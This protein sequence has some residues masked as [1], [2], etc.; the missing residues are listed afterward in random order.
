MRIQS[1]TVPTVALLLAAF[2]RPSDELHF[3]PAEKTVVVKSFEQTTTFKSDSF[4]MKIGDNEI[5]SEQLGNIKFSVEENVKLGV[6]DEYMKVSGGRPTKLK[7]TY[8]TIE[9]KATQTM[10]QGDEDGDKGEEK[11]KKTDLAGKTVIFTWDEK[12]EECAARRSRRRPRL[13]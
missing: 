11:E 8:D 6:T 12:K 4:S 10:S 9:S 3:A 5:P 1:V 7:R 13:P 2:A